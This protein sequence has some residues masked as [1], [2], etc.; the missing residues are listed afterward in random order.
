M[1]KI[2]YIFNSGKNNKMVYYLKNILF[3]FLSP[4]VAKNAEDKIR[5]R[6]SRYTE[7]GQEYI[8]QRV[9]YYCKLAKRAEYMP[10]PDSATQ[11][12]MHKYK[13]VKCPSVYFFDTYAYTAH[14]KQ[15]LKWCHL[16]GDVIHV[17]D[18]PSIVKSRPLC[19]NNINSVVMKLDKVRH[20][21]YINDKKPFSS[22]LDKVIFRGAVVGKD[23]RI[24]FLKKY[25]NHPM[26]NAGCVDSN[27]NTPAEW[28][29]ELIT[30]HDHLNY[31]F[32]MA[33]EGNDVASNL[34]WVMSSNSIAVM[35]KP[36][37][38]TWF[39]E[40]Q[41]IPDY[42][43]IEIAD[44]YSNL[45]ERLNYYIK[46]PEHAAEIIKNA[47]TYVAQFKDRKREDLISLMVL[48]SYFRYTNKE[49]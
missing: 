8:E 43:Y 38:E 28:K 13:K 30:L 20:F 23:N 18:Y 7:E 21:T 33:L 45:E 9:L 2:N 32:I 14:F 37:C 15:D 24:D 4:L 16:F 47:N 34:K 22:K 3:Y 48:Q 25:H 19:E 31:K 46:H 27:E 26:V 40:G 17:P 11:L 5:R 10:L 35:P 42:H 6:F 36:T 39:M 1:G 29:R 49:L 44:D 41:L 12:S